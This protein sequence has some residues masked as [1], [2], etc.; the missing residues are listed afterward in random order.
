MTVSF[1]TTKPKAF[2]VTEARSGRDGL[3][4]GSASA[5]M[6]ITAPP[7]WGAPTRPPLIGQTMQ[8]AAPVEV[9]CLGGV[10]HCLPALT[11]GDRS[12]ARTLCGQALTGCRRP[13][14]M[15]GLPPQARRA[16]AVCPTERTNA[17]GMT[18]PKPAMTVR[19]GCRTPAIC[20]SAN[21][22]LVGSRLWAMSLIG[23]DVDRRRNA[24]G[25]CAA[26]AGP[27]HRPCCLRPRRSPPWRNR[28]L[29][30]PAATG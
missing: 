6:D 7:C 5:A 14:V 13:S 26:G 17:T 4:M 9:I 24:P 27:A 2:R 19:G 3:K 30:P 22:S 16:R 25:R 18:G 15:A 12:L 29:V 20:G 8:R 23:G 10:R 11:G 1:L 28:I 21:E